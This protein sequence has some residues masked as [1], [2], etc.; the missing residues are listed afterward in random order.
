VCN[1]LEPFRVGVLKKGEM[2]RYGYEYYV[3]LLSVR[4]RIG[5]R[6]AKQLQTE[7][8]GSPTDHEVRNRLNRDYHPRV[9]PIAFKGWKDKGKR[10]YMADEEMVVSAVIT[11]IMTGGTTTIL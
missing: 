2:M 10:N 1:R 9:G 3:N 11:A 5:I 4:K 7:L 6:V 8:G